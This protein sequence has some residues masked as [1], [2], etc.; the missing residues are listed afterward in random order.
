M[1]QPSAKPLDGPP[2]PGPHAPFQSSIRTS[3]IFS[4]LVFEARLTA[5]VMLALLNQHVNLFEFQ[6]RKYNLRLFA[7]VFLLCSSKLVQ[8]L[9][10]VVGTVFPLNNFAVVSTLTF[11]QCSGVFLSLYLFFQ[12]Y[13]SLSLP[14]LAFLLY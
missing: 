5:L 14:R 10:E 11:L 9:K 7:Y 3:I 12:V 8:R 4:K 13:D 6:L 2:K 1:K